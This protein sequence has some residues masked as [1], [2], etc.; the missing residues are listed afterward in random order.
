A[1]PFLALGHE[2]AI[3]VVVA[4]VSGLSFLVNPGSLRIVGAIALIGF[5][6]FKFL[7]PRS[8][9]K[10]IGMRV[11]RFDLVTWSFLMSSA[12]GA[13]LMLLP[14]LLGLGNPSSNPLDDFPG[15]SFGLATLLTDVAAVLIHTGTML[16]V[17]AIVAVVVYE[18]YGL[19]LLRRAWINLDRIWAVVVIGAGLS[20][21]FS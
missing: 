5:G 4:V 3:A 10:W 9:P 11:T 18:T 19:S 20:A 16:F 21:L 1:L 13:G 7:K 8:H 12:H 15:I 6:L 17:M 14:V 2:A